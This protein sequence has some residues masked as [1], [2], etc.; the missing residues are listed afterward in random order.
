[1]R[2]KRSLAIEAMHDAL[3][4][5]EDRRQRGDT[6]GLF[7]PLAEALWWIIVLNESYWESEQHRY[8][9]YR[10]GHQS[11]SLIE[12]L[13]YARNRLTHDIDIT[14]MHGLITTPF[15]LPTNFPVN[16]G[17]THRWVWRR[18]DDLPPPERRNDDGQ[19][20]YREFL[21]GREVEG[22]L[23]AAA[24]LLNEYQSAPAHR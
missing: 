10:E 18:V 9:K 24:G 6:E 21:E 16:F 2:E 14:G 13:I 11:G 12:G 4:R 5:A 1:M 20:A 17:P 23:R 19:G 3:T 8:R 22:T 15:E 7:A